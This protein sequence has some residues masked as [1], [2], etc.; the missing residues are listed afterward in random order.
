MR[1]HTQPAPQRIEALAD[2]M[3]RLTARDPRA[4]STW[5][6]T[7]RALLSGLGDVV[8]PR[9]RIICAQATEHVVALPP[10]PPSRS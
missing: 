2:A 10:S 6:Y 1:M 5:S 8:R 3:L 7:M 9:L 4:V